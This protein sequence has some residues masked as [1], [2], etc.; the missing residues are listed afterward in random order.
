MALSPSASGSSMAGRE[1]W[2][3]WGQHSPM[4]VTAQSGHPCRL[5]ARG[6]ACG[7]WGVVNKRRKKHSGHGGSASG[8]GLWWTSGRGRE[9]RG[10]QTADCRTVCS[11][12]CDTCSVANN[13]TAASIIAQPPDS[14]TP[15]GI[16]AAGC[17]AAAGAKRR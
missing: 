2:S 4:D 8:G 5:E 17:R 12:D 6:C 1:L 15:S 3:W 7:H 14:C 16:R 10:S 9:R 11:L 13:S